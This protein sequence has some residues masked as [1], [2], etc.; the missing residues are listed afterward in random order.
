MA[1]PFGRAERPATMAGAVWQM[2]DVVQRTYALDSDAAGTQAS[3]A[4]PWIEV[5]K[6]AVPRTRVLELGRRGRDHR[7]S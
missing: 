7:A 1:E 6:T 5:A 4:P 3:R 2:D